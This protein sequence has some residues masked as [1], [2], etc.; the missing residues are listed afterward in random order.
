VTRRI[1]EAGT[2]P[3]PFLAVLFI[4]VALGVG[5]RYTWTH[6]GDDPILLHKAPNLNVPVCLARTVF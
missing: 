1:L 4:T 6:P 2:R 5:S 3:L